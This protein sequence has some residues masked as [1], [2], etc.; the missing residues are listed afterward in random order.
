MSKKVVTT[1]IAVIGGGSWAT[2]LVKIL[3]ENDVKIKWWLRNSETVDFIKHFHHNPK[4]LSDVQ[5]NMKK[6]KP[7]TNIKKVIDGADYVILAIPA[8]FLSEALK[9]LTKDDFKGRIIVSGVKGIVPNSNQLITDYMERNFAVPEDEICVIGGPCHSE[10]VALEKQSYLTIGC[11]D[12]NN[13]IQFSNLLTCRYVKCNAMTDVYGIEIC[14]IM[15]NIIAILTGI[16]HGLGYGDNFQAVLISN[17]MQEVKR[18]LEVVAPA[19]R[20]LFSSAYLGDLLVTSYSNFSRNRMFGNMVGRGY[21]VKAAQV[22][23]NM[24]A[25]G[26]Y[27]VKSMNEIIKQ[28]EIEMPILK[29]VYHILYDK[30][31]PQVEIQILKNL[32]K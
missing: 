12:F 3:S 28:H 29:A 2:A 31:N 8:A 4:Y 5:L 13:A 25:E 21:S 22:E 24:I 30:V 16:T 14:A 32:L 11:K 27:A 9:P 26:Y 20:D 10:E 1:N 19:N 7:E 6:V 23:M 17:A 18:Y 15:K